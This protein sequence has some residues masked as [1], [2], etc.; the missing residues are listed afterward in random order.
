MISGLGVDIWK[1]SA[2]SVLEVG[3]TDGGGSDGMDP[4]KVPSLAAASNE[5]D[6]SDAVWDMRYSC[7]LVWLSSTDSAR[8]GPVGLRSGC[9]TSVYGKNLSTV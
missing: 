6:A 8:E 2:A 7:I 9:Q 1:G 4:I 3:T 5:P